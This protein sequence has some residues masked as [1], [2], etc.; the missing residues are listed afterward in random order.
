[1]EV[2]GY[3]CMNKSCELYG[4]DQLHFG[5][6]GATITELYEDG[7]AVHRAWG[8]PSQGERNV[9]R[10]CRTFL[11]V[12]RQ[13]HGLEIGDLEDTSAGEG[14]L[15]VDG[16]ARWRT[17]AYLKMQV[18]RA[19]P[20]DLYAEQGRTGSVKRKQ[21]AAELLSLLR[22]AIDWKTD[23]ASPDITLL[24][25]ATSAMQ[26]AMPTSVDF[27]S[28]HGEWAMSQGWESIWVVGSPFAKRLDL[29]AL[30]AEPV[31]DSWPS[32]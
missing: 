23:S 13:K 10:V 12:L 7:S 1:M 21:D 22:K 5:R 18:T 6:P 31:P 32:A 2:G 19:L 3:Y 4:K 28:A 14:E 25:D 11:A 26:L 29:R 20:E 24:I 15:G 16:R 9:P 17:G 8:P 27:I 30:G